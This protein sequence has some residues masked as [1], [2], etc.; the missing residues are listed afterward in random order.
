MPKGLDVVERRLGSN[1]LVVKRWTG[2]GDEKRGRIVLA[3][4]EIRLVETHGFMPKSADVL[5]ETLYETIAKIRTEN[6][7]QGALTTMDGGEHRVTLPYLSTVKGTFE[8]RMNQEKF[9]AWAQLRQ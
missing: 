3:K 7:T 1:D 6:P 2:R 8:A 4:K 9:K 5:Q